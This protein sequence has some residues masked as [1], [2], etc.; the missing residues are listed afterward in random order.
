MY[1]FKNKD[2][3]LAGQDDSINQVKTGETGLFI[4]TLFK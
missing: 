1:S 4:K 2:T 3:L